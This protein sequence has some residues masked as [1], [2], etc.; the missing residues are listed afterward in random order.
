MTDVTATPFQA[1]SGAGGDVRYKPPSASMDLPRALKAFRALLRNKEDTAQ[2][3]EI[4]RAL[5]GRSVARGYLRLLRTRGGGPQAYAREELIE[6]LDDD[7]AMSAYPP[8]TVGA[9]YF[10]WRVAEGLSAEGLAQESRKGLDLT[11]LETRHPYAWFG[12]RIRDVHDLWHILSGYGRDALGESCLVAFSYAQTKGPGWALI[13][14]GAALNARRL[15]GGA[16]HRAAI[17][18]GY[19]RGLKARWLLAEDYRGILAEPV[20]VARRRLGITP[21]YRYDAIAPDRRDP[22]GVRTTA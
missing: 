15:G 3:F 16:E 13:A 22:P 2:V 18:E 5:N 19:Q 11:Q 10:A 8:G 14:A 20:E 21:A 6:L 9:E 4:M 7:A 17:W 1:P 12:R